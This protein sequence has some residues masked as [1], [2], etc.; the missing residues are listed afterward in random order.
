MSAPSTDAP[1]RPDARDDEPAV[2]APVVTSSATAEVPEVEAPDAAA[3]STALPE[4]GPVLDADQV[5]ATSTYPEVPLKREGTPETKK[6]RK[7]KKKAKEK[8][9]AESNPLEEI[10]TKR[11]IETLFR[12]SYRVHMDLTS[13]ADAK[14]NIMISINGLIVGIVLGGTATRID[15]NPYLLY[16]TVALLVGCLLSLTFAVLAARPRV[17]KNPFSLEDAR[18]G[19]MNLLYFGN[20]TQISRDD[21][22]EGMRELVVS[23]ERIYVD[24]MRDLYGIGSVLDKKF[25]MLRISYGLFLVALIVGGA[26][27]I[28]AFFGVA[29]LA[30]ADAATDVIQAPN[31]ILPS[32]P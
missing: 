27:F 4:D 15:A 28:A 2:P 9:E 23:G 7:K 19:K 13:L 5:D 25:K 12:S 30:E 18:A 26:M 8:K 1:P 21:F 32:I 11:G 10:G 17:Y 24:M 14:A 20:F 31:G 22:E 6:A 29:A 16:P 3:S